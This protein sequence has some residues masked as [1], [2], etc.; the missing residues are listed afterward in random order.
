MTKGAP[1]PLCSCSESSCAACVPCVRWDVSSQKGSIGIAHGN[2]ANGS[3]GHSSTASDSSTAAV[4]S[5]RV[6]MLDVSRPDDSSQ[7]S[8][9]AAIE[10][11]LQGTGQLPVASR[12]LGSTLGRKLLSG[13]S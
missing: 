4:A 13:R 12:P 5:M 7:Q 11:A 10:S 1:D 8:F 2:L 3:Q 6:L 9:I